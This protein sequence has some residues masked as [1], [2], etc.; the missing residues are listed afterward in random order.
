[1]HWLFIICFDHTLGAK[2]L[3]ALIITEATVPW[4]VDGPQGSWWEMQDHYNCVEVID[5]LY[6]W[7]VRVCLDSNLQENIPTFNNSSDTSQ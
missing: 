5:R 6:L 1:M 4:Q 7:N 2:H 3:Q